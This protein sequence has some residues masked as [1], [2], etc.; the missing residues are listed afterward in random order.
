MLLE[1]LAFPLYI[2]VMESVPTGKVVVVRLATPPAS[3]MLPS[4][5]VPFL[6]ATR[7]EGV[8][9]CDATV[10]VKLTDCPKMEVDCEETSVVV[11]V[12]LLTT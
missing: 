6:K 11:L 8:R 4:N 10:A 9:N 12:S 7:P 1:I 2:A 5:T 3:A